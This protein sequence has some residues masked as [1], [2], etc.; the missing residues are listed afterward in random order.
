MLSEW[1]VDKGLS[2]LVSSNKSS[3]KTM[4]I[5]NSIISIFNIYKNNSEFNLKSGKF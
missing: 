5:I 2:F 4:E 1:F 3:L